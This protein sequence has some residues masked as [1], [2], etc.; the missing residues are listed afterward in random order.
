MTR[1]A[2]LL[3]LLA[4]PAFGQVV[5]INSP[6][7]VVGTAQ[8]VANVSITRN[9]FYTGAGNNNPGFVNGVTRHTINVGAGVTDNEWVNTTITNNASPSAPVVG[10]YNQAN[11]TVT[12]GR[13]WGSID[14]VNALVPGAT[15]VAHECDINV[16]VLTVGICEDF[17]NVAHTWAFM[18]V[19]EGVAIIRDA[20]NPGSYMFFNSGYLYIYRN[21]TQVGVF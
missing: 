11:I 12:G 6:I 17:V 4:F 9:A 19:S 10:T 14:E 18:R 8:D 7:T 15:A 1:L 13:S 2:A 16:D 5:T 21:Y 3:A 20:Q